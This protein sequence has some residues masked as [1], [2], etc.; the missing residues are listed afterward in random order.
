MR[1]HSSIIAI[2]VLTGLCITSARADLSLPAPHPPKIRPQTID[3]EIKIGY[4]LA[5]ADVDG[6]GREDILLADKEE[7]VW[8]QNPTWQKFRM[9]GHLTARDHVC[10]AARDI[11][12]DGM[13]EVAVGAEWNPGDTQNS[14]A[15][16]YL[17]PPQ[18][19]TKEWEPIKLP[20]EPTIHRMHWIRDRDDNFFLAVLP[21]HGRGNKN[22]EGEGIRFLGYV[23]PREPRG[24]WHTFELN[25][26]FHKAHNFDPV[27]WDSDDYA[28]ELLVASG[29]GVNV[30][31]WKDDGWE[32]ESIIPESAGEVRSGK[33]YSG[34]RFIVSIEPMHGNKVV[35][36]THKSTLTGKVSWTKN[37]VVL[38]EDMIQ[39]HALATGDMLG[40]GYDQVIAGWRGNGR[41]GDVVGIKMYVPVHKRGYQWQ[42]HALLDDNQMACEDLKLADL[43]QDGKL[44]MVACGRATKNVI[45][46]WNETPEVTLE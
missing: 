31:D 45:I 9:T 30:I 19:R 34:R 17:I 10:I 22:G 7:I 44:D 42:M 40:I 36:N 35:V 11:D 38:E 28:E 32:T 2:T 37:R 16:F 29:E 3:D 23:R 20:H 6:D 24:V 26:T 13:A 43:N 4:G 25:D 5:I 27:R 41:P 1:C 46:Y 21:L 14:G 33:L 39:G 12:N 15:I 18:D 8:Y